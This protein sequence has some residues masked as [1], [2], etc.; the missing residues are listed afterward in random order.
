MPRLFGLAAI[1]TAT[2]LAGC[3]K[4]DNANEPK[5]RVTVEA[6]MTMEIG[7][8]KQK[9]EAD[10]AFEYTWKRDGQVR[11]LLVN[12]AEVRATMGAKEMMNA[13]LSRAGF[14]DNTVGRKNEVKTAD[15]PAQLK[16]L[17]TDSFDTPICKLELDADGKEVK[18]TVVA[19]P[20]AA[21]LIDSGM[22]A[23]ARMFHPRYAANADEWEDTLEV[24][25]NNGVA[26]GK[27][28]YTKV[29]GGKGRQ[30]VKVSGTL[31]ADGVKGV[32]G[33]M[34][35]EAKYTVTG[36]QTYDPERKEWV[37][38]NMTMD[39][40]FKMTQGVNKGTAKGVMEVTFALV[41]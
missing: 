13:K 21:T 32:G 16:Q 7:G 4:K 20:G 25:S 3:A 29:P 2:V 12:S 1:L 11:T 30:V 31:T 17:L 28:T 35:D 27:A 26:T 40:A 8:E 39:V 22:I 6:K 14:I 24:S 33:V 19:G 34:I 5:F 10:A 23:N 36:E 15:A 38:G 18:R 9:I 37:K 41:P